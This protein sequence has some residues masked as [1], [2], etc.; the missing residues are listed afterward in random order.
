[1]MRKLWA[2]IKHYFDAR[3]EDCGGW[4]GSNHKTCATCDEFEGERQAYQ[5]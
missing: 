5:M 4:I 3:C 1:M 2:A